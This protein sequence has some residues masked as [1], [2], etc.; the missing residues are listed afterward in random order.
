MSEETWWDVTRQIL[1][2]MSDAEAFDTLIEQ[3]C[4]PFGTYKQIKDQLR[5]SARIGRK[6]ARICSYAHLDRCMSEAKRKKEER[7]ALNEAR[8]A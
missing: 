7:E 1:G 2:E 3:T 6:Y 8:D 5:E 4:F